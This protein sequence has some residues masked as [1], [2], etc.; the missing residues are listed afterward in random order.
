MKEYERVTFSLSLEADLIATSLES[1][2]G[3]AD[4]MSAAKIGFAIAVSSANP[5]DE[6]EK[7][8]S[9]GGGSTWNFGSY[10][11]DRQLITLV[12]TLF[13][14]SY[15]SPDILVAGLTNKGLAML[16]PKLHQVSS[17]E[18]LFTV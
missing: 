14:D 17:F 5:L 6:I 4:K 10:D 13:T 18:D 7:W 9:S 1:K 8:A 12:N 11:R 3:F 15:K 16:K 2:L